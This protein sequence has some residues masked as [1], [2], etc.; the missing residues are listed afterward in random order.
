MGRTPGDAGSKLPEPPLPLSGR[1]PSRCLSAAVQIALLRRFC[2]G[3]RAS[4]PG[5]W[6]P[7]PPA[8]LLAKTLGKA[9]MVWEF[10]WSS[11]QAIFRSRKMAWEGDGSLVVGSSRVQSHCS[12]R[13]RQPLSVGRKSLGRL[14]FRSLTFT[15]WRRYVPAKP[16]LHYRIVARSKL[17]ELN[18]EILGGKR[19]LIKGL[20]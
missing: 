8:F 10:D 18:L 11:P 17:L 14:P 19:R 15:H 4:L 16:L 5:V 20:G 3:G 1:S 12:H 6:S 2:R 13:N 9:T 7:S